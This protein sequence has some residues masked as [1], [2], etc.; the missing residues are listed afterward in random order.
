MFMKKILATSF[1]LFITLLHI[2]AQHSSCNCTAN[3]DTVIYK[4][5]TNYAGFP[6]KT[7]G[8]KKAVYNSLVKT[9]HQRATGITDPVHCFEIIKDYV[10]FFKDRHF[11]FAYKL[12]STHRRFSP[13]KE[14]DFKKKTGKNA[15]EG[16]Y[17]NPDSTI[18]IGIRQT[19]SGT[20]EGVVL[21]SKAQHIPAGLV[22]CTLSQTSRGFT[23]LRYDYLTIDYPARQ[24]GG[25]LWLWNGELWGKVYPQQMTAAESSELAT[26]KNFNQG[27]AFRQL[28]AQ[29]AYLKIPS[30]NR[31][32]LVQK[33]IS[34]NDAAIRNAPHLIIDLRRNGG[35]NTGW[36]YLLPYFMTQAID[37]GYNYVRLSPDNI[38]RTRAEM[39]PLVRNPVTEEMKKYYTPAFMEA[40]KKAYNEIPL[41]KAVFYPVPAITIPLEGVS[42]HPQKIA[43]IFDDLCG[44][45]TE[46]FF[47]LSRQSSKIKRYG[48]RTLG[49]MDY[50]GMPVATHL[51]F[52]GYHLVIPD[53]KSSWTDTAPIDATGLKPETD[54]GKIPQD[55]WVEYVRKDLSGR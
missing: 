24:Y 18:K 19:T 15:V 27:L 39:E 41:S 16:I 49:M 29:T 40:Y 51:P 37:Q 36:A 53:T 54:L 1:L 23:F 4:T 34:S 21:E 42:T 55:A 5:E 33:L 11:D 30:F 31:D 25:L 6:V 44:S 17:T 26:W 13:L 38:R 10:Y 50:A 52:K 46:Y 2:S 43:L 8:T 14:E 32:N 35:G 12:D 45:S 22:Y 9:L 28:D 3:L 48:I 7:N 20:Y 47:Q